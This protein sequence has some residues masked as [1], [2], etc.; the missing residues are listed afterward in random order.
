MGGREDAGGWGA[1]AGV[2]QNTQP[3][4]DLIP[5]LGPEATNQ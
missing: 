5:N 2:R 1:K 3:T 4:L